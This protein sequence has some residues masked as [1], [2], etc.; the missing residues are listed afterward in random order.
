[1]Y[2]TA[3]ARAVSRVWW[4]LAACAPFPARCRT[5]TSRLS[6]FFSESSD[7]L[8]KGTDSPTNSRTTCE[9]M[10]QHSCTAPRWP[11]LIPATGGHLL[12]APFPIRCCTRTSRQ[13]NIL[14]ESSYLLSKCTD[15]LPNSRTT[16]EIMYQHSCTAPR[17]P[18]LCPETG[19][20]FLRVLLSRRGA[21]HRHLGI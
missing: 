19:G 16:C 7:L 8:S 5:R 9:N 12:C 18:G 17:G 13:S 21:V 20:H 1:M 15:S 11:G 10:Y 3:W 2:S 6:N 14:S 4:S